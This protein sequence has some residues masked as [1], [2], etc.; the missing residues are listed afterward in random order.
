MSVA[1]TEARSAP[2]PQPPH[3]QG[4]A[5]SKVLSEHVPKER[6]TFPITQDP[7]PLLLTAGAPH[8]SHTN[9]ITP[10]ADSQTGLPRAHSPPACPIR[11]RGLKS[12]EP[13]GA[14]K[15]AAGE[16]SKTPPARGGGPLLVRLPVHAA[17][18]WSPPCFPATGQPEDRCEISRKVTDAAE[19]QGCLLL[20]AKPRRGLKKPL[21]TLSS[22]VEGYLEPQLDSVPAL[23][24]LPSSPRTQVAT[25][26]DSSPAPTQLPATREPGGQQRQCSRLME[27]DGEGQAARQGQPPRPLPPTTVPLLPL[28]RPH[29][30]ATLLFQVFGTRPA[31]PSPPPPTP[32]SPREQAA[33][34]ALCSSSPRP[35][36]R[37]QHPT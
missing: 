3:C 20:R 5:H 32:G 23:A 33:A 35:W 2:Q 6:A 17:E 18:T 21:P 11:P 25:T 8:H 22:R 7:A 30:S 24:F 12:P 34:K 19:M 13:F 15:E 26:A 28:P 4:P 14:A 10:L 9:S 16:E 31:S 29:T 36:G 27:E 1:E 37:P